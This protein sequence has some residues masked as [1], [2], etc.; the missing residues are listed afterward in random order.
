MDPTLKLCMLM[1]LLHKVEIFMKKSTKTN[2]S[3]GSAFLKL[4]VFQPG[5][6]IL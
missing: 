5:C 6:F 3:V 2:R 1:L 4:K